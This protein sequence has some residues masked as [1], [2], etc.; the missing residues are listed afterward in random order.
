MLALGMV[1]CAAGGVIGVTG[2]AIDNSPIWMHV[3]AIVLPFIGF[4]LVILAGR[5]Q[6]RTPVIRHLVPCPHCDLLG[7]V[8]PTVLATHII[9]AHPEKLIDEARR[10]CP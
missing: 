6:E 10:Q 9:K 7:L 3:A 1:L 5:K 8:T 2:L 4:A